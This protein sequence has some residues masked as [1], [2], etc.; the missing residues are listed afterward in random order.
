MDSEIKVSVCVVAYNQE[1]YITQ[2]LQSLVDQVTDFNFEIVVGNDCSTDSTRRII[3]SFQENYPALIFPLHHAKNVG[4]VNNSIG[5]YMRAKGKYICHMDGDDYALAG[6]IQKQVHF[7][8]NNPDCVIC[9]HD[10]AIVDK[11]GA[12]LRSSYKRHRP[13]V[14][15]LMDLYKQLPFFAHSSKMFINDNDDSFWEKLNPNAL[16]V[17][18]H[19]EQAKKGNIYHIDECL[20]AYRSFVGVSSQAVGVNPLL[21]DGISRIFESAL[22]NPNFDHDAVK[23]DYAASMFRYAYQSAVSGNIVGLRK[24]ILRSIE[25]CPFSKVQRAFSVMAK[26]PVLVVLLC[27]IRARMRGYEVF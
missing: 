15:T 10:M 27:R 5:N 26:F 13:G 21:V 14:N 16:D 2:C 17:E 3:D 7:L 6:K 12:L 11:E 4:A 22:Q 24:Y 8:E 25:L 19:V 23:R 1:K 9:S 18:V 20:G